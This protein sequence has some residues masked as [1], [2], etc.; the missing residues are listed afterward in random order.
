MS[1]V[2]F[3]IESFQIKSASLVRSLSSLFRTPWWVLK[4]RPFPEPPHLKRKAVLLVASEVSFGAF[5]ETGT[6]RGDMLA[7]IASKT[8][9]PTVQSIELDHDLAMRAIRR[10][11]K[12]GRV[13]IHCG[14]SGELLQQ[15]TESLPVP[16]LF[17]LDGHFS[18]G[19]T[20]LGDTVTPILNELKAIDACQRS[21][22][23]ILIDDVRL[24]D[25]TD[26]Y[27]TLDHLIEFIH[28]LNPYWKCSVTG[29]MLK[30]THLPS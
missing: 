6:Y 27:P 20:A 1:S 29:D 22:D 14:D 25:G 9:I 5:V 7:R 11:H 13:K 17:W 21:S 24:F 2:P 19:V 8:E 3:L 18:G 12:Q 26:G 15:L 4:G 16:A 28:E 30:I 23:V 10:F